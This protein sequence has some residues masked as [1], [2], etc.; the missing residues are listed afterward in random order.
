M[1]KLVGRGCL[2]TLLS[3][4]VEDALGHILDIGGGDSSHGDPAV[5]GEVDVRVFADLEH[6]ASPSQVDK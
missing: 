2:Y 5:V 6:L 1:Q 4:N 3:R